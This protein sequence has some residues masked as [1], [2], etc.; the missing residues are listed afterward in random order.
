MR[1]EEALG[2]EKMGNA[3]PEPEPEP[4][5]DVRAAEGRSWTAVVPGV[6]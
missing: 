5:P 6:A 3:E 2:P 1:D 4:E